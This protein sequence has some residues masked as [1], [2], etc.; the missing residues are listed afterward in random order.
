MKSLMKYIGVIAVF[1]L[2]LS[3]AAMAQADSATI[4]YSLFSE[5]HKNK[6]Y[7]SALPHGFRVL[8]LDPKKFAK[9]IYF[10]MED[11]LWFNHDSTNA[12][13]EKKKE[14]ANHMHEIYNMGMEHFAE[15][16]NYFQARKSLIVD[17]WGLGDTAT[18][19]AEYEKAFDMDS[20]L[21][22]YHLSR[23]GQYY[24][25]LAV[26]SDDYKTKALDLF[27]FLAER[28]PDNPVWVAEQ[29]KLVENIEELITLTRRTWD[30]DKENPAKA[31]KYARL[32]LRA[33]EFEKAVEPLEFLVKAQPEESIYLNQLATVYHKL[34][35]TD[36]ALDAYRQLVKME[37]DK[38]EHNL[39]I[40]IIL[41]ERGQFAAARNEFNIAYDKSGKTWGVP[42]FYEGQLYEESARSCGDDFQR[43]LIYL[44]ASQTYSRAASIEPSLTA[45]RERAGQIAGAGPTK[46]DYFFRSYKSGQTLSITCVGWIGRSITVP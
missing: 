19:I 5:F 12:D 26:N 35:Q 1:T 3:P 2:L 46:E 43:K 32:C 30:L 41:K 29:E 10:K 11:I 31:W 22:S 20:T 33:Q 42:V 25:E 21:S 17:F 4:E 39:N 15:R 7:E 23:L 13:V 36:K 8:Q 27:V 24:K 34:D 37:P 45:A 6:D 38:K 14:Y 9:W 16:K 44:L 40:G 18:V 28:E